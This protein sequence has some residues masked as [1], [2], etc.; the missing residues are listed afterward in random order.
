MLDLP[1]LEFL[2]AGC[3]IVVRACL[4]GGDHPR[5][6]LQPCFLLRG[7]VLEPLDGGRVILIALL[8]IDFSLEVLAELLLQALDLGCVLLLQA[9]LLLREGGPLLLDGG[10]VLRLELGNCGHKRLAVLLCLLQ[11][12]LLLQRLVRSLG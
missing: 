10:R 11:L 6:L 2:L 5:L 12:L 1:R 7:V 8:P 4:E 3:R 9:C